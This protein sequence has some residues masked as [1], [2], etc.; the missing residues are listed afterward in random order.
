MR[1][2]LARSP[3]QSLKKSTELNNLLDDISHTQLNEIFLEIIAAPEYSDDALA[4]LKKKK[5]RRLVRITKQVKAGMQV[6]SVPG[7]FVAQNLDTSELSDDKINLVTDKKCSDKELDDL[8]FAWVICKHTKSNAIVYVKDKKLLGAGAGQM[9]RI[10][11]TKIAS[12]KAKEHGHNLEGAVAASDAF[13]PFADGLN[14]IISNGIVSV[15]QPGG[16]VRDQE[17]IEEA[18]KNNISMIFTGIR[19]FKH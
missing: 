3:N 14:E 7:G 1:Y 12:M 8:K 10:D 18:N 6:K 9:S 2:N 13:F 5:N 15:I 11:S 16:S 19:N 17:V 4:L